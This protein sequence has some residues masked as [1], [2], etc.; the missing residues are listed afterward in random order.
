MKNY[1]R[2]VFSISVMLIEIKNLPSVTFEI[3]KFVYQNLFEI[4]RN[5]YSI[6][7]N[8]LSH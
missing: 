5:S 4:M 6:Q 8:G 7:F 3:K 1:D 2:R